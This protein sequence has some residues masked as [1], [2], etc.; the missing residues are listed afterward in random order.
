MVLKRRDK[1]ELGEE[2]LTELLAGGACDHV[3]M[4]PECR[5]LLWQPVA[6][7]LTCFG[8]FDIVA[9]RYQK[10]VCCSEMT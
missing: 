6:G 3:A 8:T 5:V 10:G 4:S 1:V 7:A 9:L 2:A